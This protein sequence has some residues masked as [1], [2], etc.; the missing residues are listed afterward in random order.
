MGLENLWS[1]WGDCSVT[2]GAGKQFRTRECYEDSL[3]GSALDCEIGEEEKQP[4][5]CYLA[6]C[7]QWGVWNGWSECTQT[8]NNG[9]RIRSRDC[10]DSELHFD[11]AV[12]EAFKQMNRTDMLCDGIENVSNI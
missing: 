6:D 10:T 1:P 11:D 3:E 2:C 8:C 4:R 7:P 5:Y 12:R 9:T